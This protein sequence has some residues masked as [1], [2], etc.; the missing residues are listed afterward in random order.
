MQKA[1]FHLHTALGCGGERHA[2]GRFSL[3]MLASGFDTDDR[4]RIVDLEKVVQ[5]A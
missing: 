4:R 5:L 1:L 2:N 3:S